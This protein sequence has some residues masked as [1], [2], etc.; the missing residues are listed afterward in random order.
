[1]CQHSLV[2]EWAQFLVYHEVGL[3]NT[4]I[5][6]DF[7]V[8]LVATAFLVEETNLNDAV[9][10]RSNSSVMFNHNAKMDANK[11][12][13]YRIFQSQDGQCEH[14]GLKKGQDKSTTL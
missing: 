9:V 4:T 1:M 6:Q 10:Q 13:H 3:S 11:I 2:G 5:I 14:F 8:R 12:R 7:P